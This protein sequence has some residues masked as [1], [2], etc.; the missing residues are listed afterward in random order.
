MSEIKIGDVRIGGSGTYKVIA[1]FEDY[2]WIKSESLSVPE[3]VSLKWVENWSEPVPDFFEEGK[4][5]Q[6]K[7]THNKVQVDRII[8]APSGRF[9]LV[10]CMNSTPGRNF[11]DP[12]ILSEDGWSNWQE[13]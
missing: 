3:S 1:L 12:R 9:A 13:Q 5:Y 6:H 8:H 4:M 10:I 11:G 7:D 2:V